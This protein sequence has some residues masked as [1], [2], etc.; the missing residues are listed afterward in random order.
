LLFTYTVGG[1]IENGHV[2]LQLKATDHLPLL[3]DGRTIPFPVAIADLQYW[4]QEPMPVILVVYDAKG[5]RA[6]WLHM[7]HYAGEQG[8]SAEDENEEQETVTVR[9]PTANRVNARAVRR[10]RGFKEAVLAQVKGDTR[11]GG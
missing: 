1:E 2:E 7:Q 9:I 5:D 3:A 11:H 6:Y 10:Y 4:L 8:I